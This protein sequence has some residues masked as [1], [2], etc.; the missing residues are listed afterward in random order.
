MEQGMKGYSVVII[1]QVE[2]DSKDQAIDIVGRATLVPGP[3]CDLDFEVA[4][5]EPWPADEYLNP[6]GA[7]PVDALPQKFPASLDIDRKRP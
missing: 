4:G 7:I 5:A 3:S 6:D 1:V 2:A